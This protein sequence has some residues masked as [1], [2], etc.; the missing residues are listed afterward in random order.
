MNFSSINAKDFVTQILKKAKCLELQELVR[1]NVR[2]S[3]VLNARNF[4][5]SFEY[6][7]R[8]IN[9][10]KIKEK[11]LSTC[12]KDNLNTHSI[13]CVKV[14]ILSKTLVEIYTTL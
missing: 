3:F 7:L 6:C 12:I 13:K 8:F 5:P 9:F 14:T 10:L 11:L 4:D 1:L 2:I